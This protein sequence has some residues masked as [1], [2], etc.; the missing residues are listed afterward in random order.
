MSPLT[1]AEQARLR[2]IQKKITGSALAIETDLAESIH[3]DEPD[4][5]TSPRDISMASARHGVPL[6]LLFPCLKAPIRLLR[7]MTEPEQ[8]GEMKTVVPIF[9]SSVGSIVNSINASHFLLSTCAIYVEMSNRVSRRNL[10]LSAHV[11]K[12]T[13]EDASEAM[14]EAL[15]RVESIVKDLPILLR[16]M[17]TF[18]RMKLKP[19]PVVP[20]EE[21]D[22]Q[23]GMASLADVLDDPE[24]SP[25]T[26]GGNSSPE[27]PT[28]DA[29]ESTLTVCEP[30]VPTAPKKNK[31]KFIRRVLQI[32]PNSFKV[33]TGTE[34]G[35]ASSTSKSFLKRSALTVTNPDASSFTSSTTTLVRP[36]PTE[37]PYIARQSFIYDRADPLHPGDKVDM[38]LPAGDSVAIRLDSNGD[39]RA[40]SL[41]AL[42]QLL[43]SHHFLD[44]EELRRSFFLSFRLFSSPPLILRA[45]CLRWDEESPVTDG[46]L[47]AAQRRVWV[48]H[49]QHVRTRLAELLLAWLDEYWRP[50]SDT[51]ILGPLRAFVDAR[52]GREAV[53][54]EL[55]ARVI[56]ALNRAEHEEHTSRL[57]RARE[58]QREGALP[59]A[60]PFDLVLRA[61]DDYTLNI[62][63]FETAAGRER[64]AGQLTVLAHRFFRTIDPEEAVAAWAT[65]TPILF[66]LQKF[67]EELLFWVAQSIL[68]LQ[69][70]EERVAMIEF[71]LDVATICVRLR[72]FSSASAIFGGLVF[73]PVER[74]SL[75]ILDVAISSKE[76]YRKLNAF[77]D[78][79][80]NFAVYRRA[81]AENDFPAVPLMAV[82]H[83]DTVSA[84]EISGPVAL[85]DDPDAEK[86]L[87]HFSAFR[88]LR[89]TICTMEACLVHYKIDPIPIIQ[90]WIRAQLAVL[91][92]AE[93]A[94]LSEKMDALSRV[95]EA[96]AP[97]PIQKGQTWLQTVK[98]SIETGVFT[99]HT[100][101]ERSAA[102]SAPRLR[103]NKSIATLLNLR[104]K[105]T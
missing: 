46:E 37:I 48:H 98:G 38:P 63:V 79:A 94:A 54:G 53:A 26:D 44:E 74:L 89:K 45:F 27:S 32:P 12:I 75:T 34:Q 21:P 78:G 65:G 62:S 99:L 33:K 82:L 6:D 19:L 68:E 104:T 87:I 100:L 86:T 56:A 84:N 59:L 64:F 95:L 43:T 13:M 4:P 92:H 49:V 61:E 14:T 103:K 40:A 77:F 58:V 9:C 10:A 73:S 11:A 5:P 18:H 69:G 39:V 35:V 36:E 83:K 42:I 41:P 66:E 50:A 90:D 76:Q 28:S 60:V 70:R 3:S 8:L 96:R 67:E 55:A 71:W 30:Q 85:T 2:K 24:T 93:H 97:S 16:I 47:T 101:P 57:Q 72:N 17:E 102:P 23:D 88:M 22:A 25:S 91:P 20:S 29:T 52:F 51:C 31:H 7:L 105:K 80:N 81:I 1:S 15:K